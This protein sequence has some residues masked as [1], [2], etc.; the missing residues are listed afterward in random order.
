M[1][2][3]ASEKKCEKCDNCWVQW[4]LLG[5]SV[6]HLIVLGLLWNIAIAAVCYLPKF[7]KVTLIRE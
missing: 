2:R 7:G 6:V 5:I 1:K 4:I 3:D